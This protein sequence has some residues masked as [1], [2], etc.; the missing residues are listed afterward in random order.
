MARVMFLFKDNYFPLLSQDSSGC[1]TYFSD[2]YEISLV[3]LV[4]LFIALWW[5]VVIFPL[6]TLGGFFWAFKYFLCVQVWRNN[7][8]GLWRCLESSV[9]IP[10]IWHSLLQTQTFLASFSQESVGLHF[11]FSLHEPQLGNSRKTTA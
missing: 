6:I 11:C 7:Q 9:Q 2:N 1:S 10:Y 3:W 5:V 4:G 8:G